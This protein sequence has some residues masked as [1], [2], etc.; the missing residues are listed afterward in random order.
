MNSIK[1]ALRPG[2]QVSLIES[3]AE[4]VNVPIKEVHKMSEKQAIG[5]LEAAGFKFKKN[6]KNLPWQH[7]LVFVNE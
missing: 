2:G 6:I 3:R 7:C 4:D 5:E 1:K